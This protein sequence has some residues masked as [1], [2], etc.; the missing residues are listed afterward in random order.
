MFGRNVLTLLQHLIKDGSVVIDVNDEITGPN[1]CVV[2]QG[3]F[4]RS[5]GP[6][7]CY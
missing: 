7:S 6:R 3:R 5:I 2:H 1:L 4:G